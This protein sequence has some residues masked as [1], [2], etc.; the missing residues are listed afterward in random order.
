MIDAITNFIESKDRPR[1]RPPE[2]R[3]TPAARLRPEA[4]KHEQRTGFARVFRLLGR[5]RPTE[6]FGEAGSLFAFSNLGENR[7]GRCAC[8]LTRS[9]LGPALVFIEVGNRVNHKRTAFPIALASSRAGAWLCP[10]AE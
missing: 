5:N 6:H 4:E 8:R 10:E 3:I 2:A 7:N 1:T 9:C